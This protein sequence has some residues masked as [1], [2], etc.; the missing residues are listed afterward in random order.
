MRVSGESSAGIFG[1]LP[2]DIYLVM[3]ISTA[4]F[5]LQLVAGQLRSLL[6][7]MVLAGLLV[8]MGLTASAS[9][10]TI[11]SLSPSQLA[12]LEAS[13]LNGETAAFVIE[14][15]AVGR[16]RNVI[17]YLLSHARW[18]VQQGKTDAAITEF[19]LAAALMELNAGRGSLDQQKTVRASAARIDELAGKMRA[20]GGEVSEKEVATAIFD[21]HRSLAHYHQHRADRLLRR[22]LQTNRPYEVE[23]PDAVFQ[24]KAGFALEAAL[25]HFDHATN[26][27][28]GLHRTEVTEAHHDAVDRISLYVEALKTR[29]GEVDAQKVRSTVKKFEAAI[30]QLELS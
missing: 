23:A 2:P 9:A 19:R 13:R 24:R 7:R 15:Q 22:S 10:Q 14:E 21:A 29:S 25:V 26:V 27:L 1:S 12:A 6:T 28:A 17:D 18:H 4:A 8:G 3:T 5:R 11:G 16:I 20:N 30:E